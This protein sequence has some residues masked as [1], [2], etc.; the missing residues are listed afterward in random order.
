MNTTSI[1]RPAIGTR[2]Q[3]TFPGNEWRDVETVTG[4]VVRSDNDSFDVINVEGEDW[5]LFD[6]EQ[7]DRKVSVAILP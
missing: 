7:C 6:I 4:I 5:T 3:V 1:I 2:V